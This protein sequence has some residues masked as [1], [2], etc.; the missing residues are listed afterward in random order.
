M[1]AIATT[2]TGRQD[3]P[4]TDVVITEVLVESVES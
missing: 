4:V 2:A 1:D 3:R